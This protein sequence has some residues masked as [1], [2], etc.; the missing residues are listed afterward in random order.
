MRPQGARPTIDHF[1]VTARLGASLPRTSNKGQPCRCTPIRTSHPCR[2][3]SIPFLHTTTHPPTQSPSWR[4]HLVTTTRSLNC[5]WYPNPSSRNVMI[6]KRWHAT[7]ENYKHRPRQQ[8]Q[9]K[10]EKL[11]TLKNQRPS[12]QGPGVQKI[13]PYDTSVSNKRECRNEH[14]TRNNM[15]RVVTI[16][17]PK[18]MQPIRSVPR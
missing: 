4:H 8:Q 14:P 10:A 9:A 5:H 7:N 18:S 12:W 16:I 13:K 17:I 11:S 2:P 1:C 6:S 15:L 3:G